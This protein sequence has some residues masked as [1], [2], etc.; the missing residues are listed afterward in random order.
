MVGYFQL[1]F[2]FPSIFHWSTVARSAAEN[3]TQHKCI[4]I[5]QMHDIRQI[6]IQFYN[7]LQTIN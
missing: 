4:L 5:F 7:Q 3:R 2:P 6:I 1:I